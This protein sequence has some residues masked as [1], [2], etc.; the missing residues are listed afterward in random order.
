VLQEKKAEAKKTN[1]IEGRMTILAST[2]WKI[3]FSTLSVGTGK[4]L[5]F[6]LVKWLEI[7]TKFLSRVLGYGGVQHLETLPHRILARF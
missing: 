1:M 6:R 2:G 3:I 5:D 7:K 4:G